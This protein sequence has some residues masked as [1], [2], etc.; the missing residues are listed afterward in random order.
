MEE[1]LKRYIGQQYPLDNASCEA[2]I[3]TGRIVRFRKKDAIVEKGCRN[4]NLYLILDGIW[5]PYYFS[6]DRE[7]TMYFAVPGEAFLC[8]FSYFDAR[9]SAYCVESSTDSVAWKIG[10]KD[11][12]GLV[13]R[14][15]EISHWF[16][17]V[18]GKAL[19]LT[20]ETYIEMSTALA[21]DRYRIFAGKMP[22]VMQ[23]VP[24]KEIAAYLGVTPQSLSRIRAKKI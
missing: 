19:S 20:E 15:E 18:L 17:H 22:Y 12:A 8:A 16:I 14:S 10:K 3:G 6:Y 24:L 2:L 4:D 11:L 21:A 1:E 7:V 5:R 9:P 13:D 23:H